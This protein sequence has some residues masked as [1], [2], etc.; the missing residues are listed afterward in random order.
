GITDPT[1]AKSESQLM[2]IEERLK[3]VEIPERIPDA[4]K[5][6]HAIRRREEWLHDATALQF[7]LS[8]VEMAYD[9]LISEAKVVLATKNDPNLPDRIRAVLALEKKINAPEKSTSGSQHD[10]R[11]GVFQF[12]EI[13]NRKREWNKLKEKL[14]PA[15]KSEKP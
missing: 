13:E 8:S 10:R 2:Q 15:A 3:R 12:A 7:A 1:T 6:S 14:E 11:D 9:E 5:E 4:F